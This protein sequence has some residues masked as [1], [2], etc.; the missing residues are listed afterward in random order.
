MED[1]VRFGFG[2]NWRDFKQGSFN[3]KRLLESRKRIQEFH[4]R[5]RFDGVHVLDIGCGSG[6][7]SLA[8]LEM[9]ARVTAFDF[10]PISVETTRKLIME[11]YKGSSAS[12]V[13]RGDVLDENFMRGLGEFDLVYGASTIEHWHEDL[14]NRDDTIRAYREDVRECWRLLRPGGVLLMNAPMFVH[15]NRWFMRGDVALVESLFGDEWRSVVF[16]HWRERHDDLA[17]YCPAH[18]QRV[19]REELGIDLTNIWILNVVATK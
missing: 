17:P 2:L 6:L 19:F 3:E 14:E 9:G 7:S 5:D 4:K 15:G 16:E 1:D 11:N 12:R 18:R 13:F 10:D 8:F